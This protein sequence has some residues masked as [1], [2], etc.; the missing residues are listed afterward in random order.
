MLD[1][2]C[3]Q[4]FGRFYNKITDYDLGEMCPSYEQDILWDYFISAYLEYEMLTGDEI[5]INLDTRTIEQEITLRQMDRI[6]SGMVYYWLGHV[7]YD[8]EGLANVTNTKEFQQ[9][10][11]EKIVARIAAI[12]D[13]SYRNFR[14]GT[15]EGSFIGG[16]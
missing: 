9:F 15:I 3:T 7:L 2:D 4:L 12:R 13:D 14:F 11:P 8:K 16:E 5:K 6:A 1:T 10:S